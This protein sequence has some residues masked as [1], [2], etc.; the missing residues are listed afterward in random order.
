MLLHPVDFLG[1]DD[2]PDLGFF[3]GM[4]TPANVKRDLVHSYLT[5]LTDHFEVRPIGE[6]AGEVRRGAP[7]R[8][9][10]PQFSEP[11]QRSSGAAA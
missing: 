11:A 6:H 1:P 8:R 10:R 2:A 5:A 4:Q 7:L 3:P 9:L